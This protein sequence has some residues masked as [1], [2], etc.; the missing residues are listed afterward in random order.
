MSDWASEDGPPP[1]TSRSGSNIRPQALSLSVMSR[2]HLPPLHPAR[3][4]E[5]LENLLDA[6]RGQAPDAKS[7]QV[8]V[9]ALQKTLDRQYSALES[10]DRKAAVLLGAIL[11]IGVLNSD[12]LQAP[13]M[14]ALVPFAIAI[15]SSLA[16]VFSSLWVLWSRTLLTGP[17][18]I[19]AAQATSWPEVPFTQSVA[20]SLAVA[21]QE[22]AG[23]NEVKGAWLNIAFTAAT[24]AV[25]SFALLGLIGGRPVIDDKSSAPSQA[26][27]SA[28]AASPQPSAATSPRATEAPT[29]ASTDTPAPSDSAFVH[30]R[31]GVAE[32]RESWDPKA[33]PEPKAPPASEE[34][35][36]A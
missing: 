6:P 18:P 33:V 20:D 2:W 31:L 27:T 3:R 25:I 26:P 28:P 1:R 12:R 29:P 34:D 32:L 7:L 15:V 4:R 16:A 35:H 22:N 13:A 8:I 24:I 30:P 11:G 9:T 21:A 17:N 10:A 23:V 36:D 14:P 5:E 19:R